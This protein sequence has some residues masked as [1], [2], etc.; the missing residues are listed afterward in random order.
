[1]TIPADGI[2]RL[3]YFVDARIAQLNLSKEEVARRGGPSRDTLAKI[4]G[5]HDQRT[6]AVGTLLRLDQS[7]GW[8]P[9]SSAAT[10][11]GGKP[12]SLTARRRKHSSRHD[13]ARPLTETEVLRRLTD[14]LRDEIV[15]LEGA[16]EAVDIRIGKLRGIYDNIVAELDIDDQL[17]ADYDDTDNPSAAAG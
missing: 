2:E 7:L 10:L 4:R 6:P 11:L 9:G 17:V 5:R 8:Q 13:A 16:R 3:I 15:R 12:L 1:M 14:Q